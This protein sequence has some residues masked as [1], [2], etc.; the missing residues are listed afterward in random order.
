MFGVTYG[1]SVIASMRR[2][3]PEAPFLKISYAH[4]LVSLDQ[5]IENGLGIN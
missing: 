4:V 2:L 1:K 3:V 5:V